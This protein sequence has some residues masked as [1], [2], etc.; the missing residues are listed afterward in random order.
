MAKRIQIVIILYIIC[1][2]L[3][4]LNKPSM[5]FDAN[6]EIK[7]FSYD[8][9]DPSASL[10]SVEIVLFIMAIFCY[11]IVIAIELII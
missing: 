5:M 9:N 6:G 11:L 2:L 1:L 8:D 7:H 3:I 4:F 10:I